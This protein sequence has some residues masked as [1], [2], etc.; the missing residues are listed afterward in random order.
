MDKQ[1]TI[2]KKSIVNFRP[3][4]DSEPEWFYRLRRDG[5]ESY[6]HSL[7]PNRASHLWRYSDPSLF[8]LEKPEGF[9]T[10][11]PIIKSGNNGGAQKSGASANSG[12][13]EIDQDLKIKGVIFK[14]LFT[15]IRLN[16]SLVEQYFGKIIDSNYGLFESLNMA[17]WNSGY[18]LYVP[19]NVTI[20][21]PIVLRNSGKGA[22]YR[23]LIA[24]GN[25]SK[26]TIVDNYQSR[27]SVTGAIANDVVELFAGDNADVRYINLQNNEK[28]ISSFLN[29]RARIGRDTN[30]QSVFGGFGGA[31]SK[32]NAGVE[33]AGRG[34][35]SRMDGIVF[36][37]SK[38]HFDYHTRHHHSASDS[39]SDLNFKVVLKDNANSAYTGL[40]RI[41]KDALNCEAYQENRN[42][43]L[44][45][46]AKAES[47][48]ELEILTDQVRCT[49][50]ATMGPIDPEMVFYLK[51]RGYS[52][53]QAVSAIVGGFVKSILD[54]FPQDIARE[55]GDLVTMKLGDDENDV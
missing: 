17:L 24:L 16:S 50:G 8:T 38:Q 1:I 48:P 18:F 20:D 37:D 51:S 47:I 4:H 49:H 11:L 32:V 3:I 45:S 46:G 28:G 7:S 26:V 23:T 12:I 54:G 14:D 29:Y 39:Y 21:E 43:L 19:D 52:E 25:N 27:E 55:I 41:E 40:I 22:F 13:M 2:T 33:L 6:R 9:F 31:N 36:A 42:L 34:S 15:A 35:R 53:N 10:N 44:N 5:W 30:I